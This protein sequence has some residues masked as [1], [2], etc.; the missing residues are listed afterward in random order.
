MPQASYMIFFNFCLTCL[1]WC[2]LW[3]VLHSSDT[4]P[5]KTIYSHT[6]PHTFRKENNPK[7][8]GKYLSQVGS[9]SFTDNILGCTPLIY[10]YLCPCV[11]HLHRDVYTVSSSV[12]ASSKLITSPWMFPLGTSCK[13]LLFTSFFP[14]QL[15][16]YSCIA[17]VHVLCM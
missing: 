10:V 8:V 7:T 9:I 1:T 13:T 15:T 5:I 4:C 2:I 3:S 16:R 11:C 14:T 17:C 12:M 6:N